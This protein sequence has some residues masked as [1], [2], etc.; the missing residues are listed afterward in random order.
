MKRFVQL[1]VALLTFLIVATPAMASASLFDGSKDAACQGA[2]LNSSTD[3]SDPAVTGSADKVN[4]TVKTAIDIFSAIVG[5]IAVVMIIVSGLK[6]MTSGGDPS[7]TNNAKDSLLYALIG[8]IV[9][10]LSQAIVHFVLN[11]F[12][13]KS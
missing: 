2:E 8:L 10:A 11:R 9:V 7:K 1:S 5:V 12:L 6:Y 4:T 13:T 3:C